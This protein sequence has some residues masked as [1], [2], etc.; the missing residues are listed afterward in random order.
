MAYNYQ[1]EQ[2]GLLYYVHEFTLALTVGNNAVRVAAAAAATT[3][4]RG[5][6]ASTICRSLRRSEPI[7]DH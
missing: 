4:S 5:I 6:T 2:T 1:Q 3:K 7:L